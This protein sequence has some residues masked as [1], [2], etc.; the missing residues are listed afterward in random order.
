MGG[1]VFTPNELRTIEVDVKNKIFRVNGEN[2][3]EDCTAFSI[4]CD[5]IDGYAIRMEIDTTVHFATYGMENG[6]EKES[7]TYTV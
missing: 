7:H 5:A 4:S 3:G 1:T 6:K 2:F